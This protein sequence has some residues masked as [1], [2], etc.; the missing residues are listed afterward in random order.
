LART[1]P[2]AGIGEL[3][4]LIIR[5]LTCILGN[6]TDAARADESAAALGACRADVTRASTLARRASPF[7]AGRPHRAPSI[8]IGIVVAALGLSAKPGAT[9]LPL[10]ASVIATTGRG[11]W[12]TQLINA[13]MVDSAL[14]RTD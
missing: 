14:V 5:W 9:D 11:R 2:D 7:D 3:D 13:D 12:I 10:A 6:S 8:R 4:D 1:T